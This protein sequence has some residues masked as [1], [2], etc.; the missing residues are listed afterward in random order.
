MHICGIAFDDYHKAL[1]AAKQRLPTPEKFWT[2][3][4][5]HRFPTFGAALSHILTFPATSVAVESSH[6]HANLVL[7]RRRLN[8]ADDLAETL[9]ILHYDQWNVVDNVV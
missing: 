4:M 7:N 5:R 6:A 2:A 8:L 1:A 9:T 3:R